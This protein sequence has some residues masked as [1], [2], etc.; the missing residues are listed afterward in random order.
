M[1][2]L[3]FDN[4][5]WSS[6]TDNITGIANRKKIR[7][8]WYGQEEKNIP[9]LELKIRDGRLGR[10]IAYPLRSLQ[11]RLFSMD[12]GSIMAEV[13]REMIKQHVII[14][15]DLM[16]TLQVSYD[17]EYYEDL[18]G[19]R[20]TIDQNIK[21]FGACSNQKLSTTLCTPYPYKVME[22]KF[23]PSLKSRVSEL[24]R[25]LHITT[26]RHSKYLVGLAMLGYISY[27]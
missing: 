19:I 22:I 8:R 15:E 26:K 4:I 6:V 24:M 18:D 21:F 27:V 23:H 17:R 2:S 25:P 1:S 7:L 12:I 5:N 20:I 13:K 16:S 10:K 14:D 11:D 3:Y 9:F